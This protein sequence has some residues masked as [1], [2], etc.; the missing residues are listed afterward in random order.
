M[1][2]V[3]QRD[4]DFKALCDRL[5][6]RYGGRLRI[7]YERLLDGEAVPNHKRDRELAV[8]KQELKVK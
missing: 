1:N 5:G 7:L 6:L 8:L 3:K 4:L 2:C